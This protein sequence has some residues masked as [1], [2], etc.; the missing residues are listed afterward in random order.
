MGNTLNETAKS[1]AEQLATS[2][3][4]VDEAVKK[5]EDILEKVDMAVLTM[6]GALAE[7]GVDTTDT[8]AAVQALREYLKQA[9]AV[10]KA[11]QQLK[12]N[13]NG[14]SMSC[15]HEIAEMYLPN[16]TSAADG[17]HKQGLGGHPYSRYCPGQRHGRSRP[18]AP[19]APT[20]QGDLQRPDAAPTF[21]NRLISVIFT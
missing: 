13:Q 2:P 12:V 5:A 4:G 6:E 15:C 7:V 14:K 8:S 18:R 1:I 17:G 21:A 9:R 3:A 16:P 19:E 10:L 11:V 20:G